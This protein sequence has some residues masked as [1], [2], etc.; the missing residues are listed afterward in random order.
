VRANTLKLF[1]YPLTRFTCVDSL[2]T[3][4]NVSIPYRVYKTSTHPREIIANFVLSLT[5]YGYLHSRVKRPRG[6]LQL[7]LRVLTAYSALVYKKVTKVKAVFPI[8]KLDS[9]HLENKI[10]QR[11]VMNFVP[12]LLHKTDIRSLLDDFIFFA[13]T[14]VPLNIAPKLES[15]LNQFKEDRLFELLEQDTYDFDTEEMRI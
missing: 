13:V 4:L 11:R 10:H 12:S 15:K 5:N 8:A 1:K 9:N 7:T 2:S 3:T 6:Y 14:S